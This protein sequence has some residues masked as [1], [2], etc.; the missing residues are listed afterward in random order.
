MD[1]QSRKPPS[2]ATALLK[3]FGTNPHGKPNW[4]V[5]WSEDRV[6][7]ECGQWRRT[8]G[9]GR[10][11]WMVERW[12]PP[13]TYGSR[14]AWETMREPDGSMSL[15]PFPSEGDYEWSFTFETPDG[16]GCPLDPGL[17]TLL[18]RCIEKGRLMS[19]AQRK[20]AIRARLDREQR[21]WEE[22]AGAIFDEAQGPFGGNAVSGIPSKRRPDDII[23]RPRP[24]I[25]HRFGSHGPQQL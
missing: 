21:E 7:F 1:A 15:G 12:C 2:W 24:E 23:I 10:N 9:E 3:Q 22:R 4:R 17:L 5:I 6:R 11:R 13:D 8:Y 20:A 19:D 18:C 25:V 14:E 16:Q